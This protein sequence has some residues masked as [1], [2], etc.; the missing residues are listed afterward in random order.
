MK[1]ISKIKGLR[2][3]NKKLPSIRQKLFFEHEKLQRLFTCPSIWVHVETG[4]GVISQSSFAAASSK[5]LMNVDFPVAKK[6][7]KIEIKN[8]EKI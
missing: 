1:K 5:T 4:S 3:I 6:C 7:M 8:F 2:G